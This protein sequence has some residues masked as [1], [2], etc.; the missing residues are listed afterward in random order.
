MDKEYKE[1]L[2]G[3][4]YAK[5]M[6]YDATLEAIKSVLTEEQQAQIKLKIDEFSNEIR[7]NGALDLLLV[8]LKLDA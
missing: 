3:I 4:L 6:C 1:A 7:K 8:D 2:Y 5:L